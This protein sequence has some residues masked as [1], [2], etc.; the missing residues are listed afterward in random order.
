MRDG[1]PAQR[2]QQRIAFERLLARLPQN[3]E[4]VLKGG[5]ALLFR[6]GLQTRPTKDIDLR[7]PR[8]VVESV[9]RFRQTIA[10]SM[11]NDHFSFEFGEVAQEMQG[12]PGGSRRIRVDARVAGMDFA[13]FHVD[14]SSGDAIVDQPDLLQ[15]SD[16][17]QFAGI[18]PVQFPVYPVTQHL[19]EKLHA[20]TLPRAQENTRVKDLVDLIIIASSERVAA[21]RLSRSVDAT[22]AARG[23]HQ[24]PRRLPEP[25]V[26]WGK[27]F[28]T[29][30][31]D[32]VGMLVTELRQ[33]HALAVQF[34]DPFLSKDA[35]HRVWQPDQRRWD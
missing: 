17:L 7:T 14:L 10:A 30:A 6:Y 12:A 8:D 11:V 33:G 32:V 21:D 22:F 28:A 15:G 25:P 5:L 31:H 19:A 4:W 35:I 9:G 3:G 16:L 26:A 23:T 29:L 27:P 1:I 18:A 34:W 24:I 20:Y 2:V 13:T